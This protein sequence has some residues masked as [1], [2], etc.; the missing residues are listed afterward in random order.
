MKAALLLAIAPLLLATLP[1]AG[2]A[3]QCVNNIPAT[4]PATRFDVND[5]GTVIDRKLHLMWARCSV[6]QRWQQGQCQGQATQ[7]TWR[8]A[9]NSA[10]HEFFAGHR[11]WR[12]PD[13]HEFSS[14]AELRCRQPAI[15]L[16]VFPGTPA[17]DY[18][19][20][21]PFINDALYAWRVHFQYGENHTALHNR[22]AAVRLVRKLDP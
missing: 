9:L 5:D 11:D 3:Q 13:V 6:G 22:A 2:H 20:S 21:T 17:V 10:A 15:N 7:L 8:D 16:A 12:L 4:A 19:T 14:L 1:A 18:W